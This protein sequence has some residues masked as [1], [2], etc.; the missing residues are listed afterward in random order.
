MAEGESL[1]RI[2]RTTD[3]M[4]AMSTIMLWLVEDREFS[5]NYAKARQLGIDIEFEKLQEDIESQ[6]PERDEKGRLDPGWVAWRRL[7]VD[8]KKWGLAKKSP[9]KYGDQ[10]TTTHELGDSVARVVREVIRAP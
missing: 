1:L 9:K 6:Q 4:P 2:V 3:G 10:N 5:E 7:Q 8:T